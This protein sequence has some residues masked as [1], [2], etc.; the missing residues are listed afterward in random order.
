MRR[1][2]AK[3]SKPEMIVRR[4]LRSLGYGYRLHG[5]GLPGKPDIV[6]KKRKTVIFVHGCFWHR[7]PE[8]SCRLARMP[9]SRLDYWLPKLETNA[10]SDAKV[11]SDLEATGWR[12]HTVWECQL[13]DLDALAVDLAALLGP[14]R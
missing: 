12:V 10:T 4:L 8:P 13:K 5:A 6:M 9:K 7:H 3:N 11:K 2:T 1:I 14:P